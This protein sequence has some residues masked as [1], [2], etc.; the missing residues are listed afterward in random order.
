MGYTD[1]SLYTLLSASGF[2]DVQIFGPDIY[3]TRNPIANVVG[4]MLSHLV[5]LIFRCLYLLYG[6]RFKHVMTKSIVA[7][8][9]KLPPA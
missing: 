9:R 1:H 2:R 8:V 7:V 6:V 4:K 3:V 5:T